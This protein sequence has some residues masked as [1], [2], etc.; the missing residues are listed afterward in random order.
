MLN[1]LSVDKQHVVGT[2]I[3]YGYDHVLADSHNWLRL[4]TFA[5]QYAAPG[6]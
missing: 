4:K 5:K 6:A 1:A 2:R 3:M